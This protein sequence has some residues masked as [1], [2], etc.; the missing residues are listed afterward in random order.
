MHKN[1]EPVWLSTSGIS[2]LDERGNLLGYRGADTDIT[3]RKRVEEELSKFEKR[4][5]T[6]FEAVPVEIDIAALDGCVLDSNEAI[7]QITG[8]PRTELK[9][10]DARDIYGTPEETMQ[11]YGGKQLTLVTVE[12]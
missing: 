10:L 6:L 5:R 12:V 11:G 2:I 3:E 8:Y 7:C 1:G 4:Y 9:Q